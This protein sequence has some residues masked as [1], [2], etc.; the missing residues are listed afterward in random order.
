MSKRQDWQHYVWRKQKLLDD[1]NEG[2]MNIDEW[3]RYIREAKEAGMGC[4]ASS[5]QG[6][7]NHYIGGKE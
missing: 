1:L 3:E 6:R 2:R 7:L 4:M 5:M